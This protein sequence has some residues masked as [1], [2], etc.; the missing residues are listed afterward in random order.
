MFHNVF[1]LSEVASCSASDFAYSYTFLRNLV[2]LSVYR[3]SHSC[4]LLYEIIFFVFVLHVTT[5]KRRNVA[6]TFEQNY[7]HKRAAGQ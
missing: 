5:S 6:E 3:L 1:L 7:A 4:T 2:C